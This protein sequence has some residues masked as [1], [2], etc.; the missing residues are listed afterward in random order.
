MTEESAGRMAAQLR[1][2]VA[3]TKQGNGQE[4]RTSQLSFL[5]EP[6]KILVN[7][8]GEDRSYR[9]QSTER[10]RD[11]I[12]APLR[13]CGQPLILISD[14]GQDLDDEMAFIMLRYLVHSSLVD[15]RGVICTLHPSFDRARLCRGTLDTLGLYDVPVGVGTDGGNQNYK[16]STFEDWASAYMPANGSERV[17]HLAPGFLVLSRLFQKAEPKSLTI[18]VIA[19]LKD[20]AIFLRD[21]T[22]V[23]QEKVKEVVIMGGVKDWKTD[24]DCLMTPSESNEGSTADD[25]PVYELLPDTAHNQEFDHKASQYLYRQCQQL[26]IPIVV[27]SRWAAYASKVSRG[28]YDELSSMGSAIG[29][30]LRN[31]Q[32]QGIENLWSRACAPEG[33]AG[34]EGLPARCDSSWFLKTFCDDSEEGKKRSQKDSIWDLVAGF[35]QY[36]TIAL[37]ACIPELRYKFFSPIQVRGQLDTTHLVI[38]QNEE[39]H[40]INDPKYLAE[41]LHEG[42]H[43]G[44]TLNNRYRPQF[45]LVAEPHW[46]EVTDILLACSLL[47]TL[48]SLGCMTCVGIVI[49]PD[50]FHG[51][52]YGKENLLRIKEVLC[53]LGLSDIPVLVSDYGSDQSVADLLCLYQKVGLPGLTL[54][55]TGCL[56]N[57]HRFAQRHTKL[58]RDKTQVIIHIGGAL[59]TKEEGHDSTDRHWLEPDLTA[60]SNRFDKKEAE[61]F[62]KFAQESLIPMLIISHQSAQACETHAQVFRAFHSTGGSMGK[63]LYDN[64]QSSMTKTWLAACS[65]PGESETRGGLPDKCDRAWFLKRFAS[66]PEADTGGEEMPALEGFKGKTSIAILAILPEV[67]RTC[68]EVKT[69]PVRSV[70]HRL[71]GVVEEDSPT[72]FSRCDS[73]KSHSGVQ[74]VEFLRTTMYQCWFKG[75]RLN[76]SEFE[77]D[78]KPGRITIQLDNGKGPGWDFDKSDGALSWLCPHRKKQAQTM[79]RFGRIEALSKRLSTVD[80]ELCMRSSRSAPNPTT[81]QIWE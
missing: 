41:M 49:A 60:E 43:A 3:A 38:G 80:P 61:G 31:A 56:G 15:V 16:A 76:A 73:L 81:R 78:K 36:D 59:V 45:I 50:P 6:E 7:G 77:T 67:L 71:I 79:Q 18:L 8:A 9:R 57:V 70:E 32:R 29:C 47:R 35:M 48:Y 25:E 39:Q 58:L 53:K 72:K 42:F 34:R 30:R 17:T 64:W 65:P 12:D 46:N 13:R 23:F 5:D 37:L 55:V 24:P 62:F 44:L 11:E 1:E 19:S 75:L 4:A 14:P 63:L 69:V 74:D 54:V 52:S 28:C 26:G 21:N 51:S 40:G 33:D 2:E 22:E 27:V 20:L 10:E 66:E 68:F